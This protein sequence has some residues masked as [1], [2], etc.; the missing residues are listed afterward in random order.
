MTRVELKKLSKQQLKGNWA[1]C[2][3]VM[4]IYFAI[5]GFFTYLSA[6]ITS[7]MNKNVPISVGLGI[8]GIIGT[9]LVG[10]FIA[11]GL[12]R[13]FMTLVRTG[14]TQIE[15]LISGFKIFGKVLGLYIMMAIFV[16]LWTLLF[17][18]PGIIAIYRYRMAYYI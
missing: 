15:N 2:A 14:E 8:V 4:L 9:I 12:A 13:F 10:G 3:V 1:T 7:I 17:V 11:Y 16:Y 6:G 5:T 18:V